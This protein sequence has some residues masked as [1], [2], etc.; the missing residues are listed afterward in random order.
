M[1]AAAFL[2]AIAT[3][4]S[5]A[6]EHLELPISVCEQAKVSEKVLAWAMEDAREILTRAGVATRWT[7][8]SSESALIKFR[9]LASSGQ[10]QKGKVLGEAWLTGTEEPG[11]LAD[12]YL[13][14]IRERAFTDRQNAALLARVMAHEVGHLLG[15]VHSLRG[16]MRARWSKANSMTGDVDWNFGQ[17][18]AVRLRSAAE[19]RCLR[20]LSLPLASG[21]SR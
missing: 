3:P 9:I 4:C 17:E 18:E 20:Q 12:V 21:P 7:H 10:P 14:E 6:A 1:K 8:C 2:W 16:I 19:K 11:F 5:M 13:D 15:A